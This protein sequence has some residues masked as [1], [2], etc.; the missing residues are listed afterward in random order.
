MRVA[1]ILVAEALTD[2]YAIKEFSIGEGTNCK[3]SKNESEETATFTMGLN[4][5]GKDVIAEADYESGILGQAIYTNEKVIKDWNIKKVSSSDPK[6]VL[7]NAQF[8]LQ[9]TTGST[10]YYGKS[11]KTGIVKWYVNEDCTQALTG[12]I[13]ADMYQLSEMK[14]PDGYAVSTD[15]WMVEVTKNGALKT[16]TSDGKVIE[17]NREEGT[18]TIFFQFEN[19]PVYA[20]PEAGGPGIFWYTAGGTLLMILA[21][22]LALYKKQEKRGSASK[23][24]IQWR[25]GE[26]SMSKIKKVLAM[27]LTL[28]LVLGMGIT[29]FAAP[30]DANSKVTVKNAD[31]ATLTIAQVIETDNTAVTGWKFTDGA[32]ASYRTAFGGAANGDDDQRIIAG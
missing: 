31:K 20:L 4:K 13:A 10:A 19:D 2:G 25:K 27:L 5:A 9:S 3:S 18:T 12:K 23:L 6:L 15:I 7:A 24:K 11:D 21:G 30:G 26:K 28:A 17:G 29:T 16:I 14:A 8:K 22:M 32:A 1:N